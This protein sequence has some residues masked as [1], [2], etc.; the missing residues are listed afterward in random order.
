VAL[1]T[2]PWM[3]ATWSAVRTNWAPLAEFAELPVRLGQ[4][5]AEASIAIPAVGWA[6]GLPLVWRRLGPGDHALLR[7]CGAWLALAVVLVP[8]AMSAALLEV[9]G[10]RYLCGLLPIAAAVTG[11]LIARASGERNVLYVALLALAAM[12][13]LLG[14]AIP[15]LAIGESRRIAGALV[16][17]PR[18]TPDK[19]FNL[20][21]WNFVN[22]LGVR[23]PG[24]LP[25]IVERLRRDAAS[26]D[27]VLTNFGWDGLYYY[28]RLPQAWRIAP[29]A[30]VRR[31]ARALGLSA[32][33]FGIDHPDWLVWRGDNEALLGYAFSLFGHPLAFVRARL[34]ARG[35]RLERIAM[36]PE[37]LWDNRPELFWHRFPRDPCPFAPRSADAQCPRYSD[38]QI[39]RVHW[40]PGT[41]TAAG[42]P[43][44]A[45]RDA[46]PSDSTPAAR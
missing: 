46:Q 17:V 29:E 6:L 35:A 4:L 1:F 44:P 42:N 18:E 2:L 36:F 37:T 41:G 19:L 30:P 5:G 15:S 14:S 39:F 12:T 21:W 22:G 31:K 23:D 20:P 34:E 13:H 43:A 27:V 10:L 32:Y 45:D 9:V 7:L 3:A 8:L 16:H 25:S 26:D 28:S 38:A 40:P 33:V 24:T 11:L